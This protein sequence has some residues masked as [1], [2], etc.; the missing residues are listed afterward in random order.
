MRA[1]DFSW[2]PLPDLLTVSSIIVVSSPAPPYV[3]IINPHI[4]ACIDFK[5]RYINYPSDETPLL[6][7]V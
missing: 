2:N 7:N 5:T 6:K 4:I 3:A 1:A